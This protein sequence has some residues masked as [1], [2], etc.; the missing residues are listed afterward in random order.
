MKDREPDFYL[1]SSE[2]HIVGEPRMCFVLQRVQY[3]TRKDCLLIHIFPPIDDDRLGSGEID[4]VVLASRFK[5]DSLFPPNRWPLEVYILPFSAVNITEH[6]GYQA[7]EPANFAWGEIYRNK[8][9]IPPANI[10]SFGS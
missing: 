6:N 1:V 10:Y 2:G 3:S 7:K 5:G 9:E 4:T 8:G